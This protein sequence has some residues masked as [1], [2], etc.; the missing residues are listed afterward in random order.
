[1]LVRVGR[2]EVPNE[3]GVG[4]RDVDPVVELAEHLGLHLEYLLACVRPVADVDQVAE[5][6]GEDLLELGRDGQGR[7]AH[8][9]E[10]GP[11]NLADVEVPVDDVHGQVERLGDQ[12]ELEVDLDEPVDEDRPHALVDE[13]LVVHVHVPGGLGRL[14]GR[15]G[16]VVGGGVGRGADGI[17]LV[18]LVDVVGRARVLVEGVVEGLV[19]RLLVVVVVF[20]GVI[21]AVGR[22]I[23]I[24]RSP[25]ASAPPAFRRRLVPGR[26][27]LLPLP[28]RGRLLLGLLVLH[29]VRR[30]HQLLDLVLVQILPRPVEVRHA[31]QPLRLVELRHHAVSGL[32][33]GHLGPH[34]V[35]HSD[36]GGRLL[37]LLVGRLGGVGRRGV[38]GR[39]PSPGGPAGGGGRASPCRRLALVVVIP[40]GFLRR[41][42]FSSRIVASVIR[43]YVCPLLDV[44]LVHVA[45]LYCAGGGNAM[46]CDRRRE[47]GV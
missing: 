13:G 24:V 27:L 20:G 26:G 41:G 4:G 6:G 29:L 1:M 28:L 22:I 45:L 12:L 15:E 7:D 21:A 5:L 42:T 10:L 46:Q 37:G 8:E 9:L 43:L 25:P 30:P 34:R 44:R 17:V 23:V 16:G 35:L 14:A 32:R 47:G 33:L 11:G 40:R 19:L 36:H 18:A 39:G 38:I 3:E 2:L 31:V